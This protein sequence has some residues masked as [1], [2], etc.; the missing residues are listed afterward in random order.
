MIFYLLIYLF[1]SRHLI[2]IWLGTRPGARAP[3]SAVVAVMCAPRR[4]VAWACSVRG[5]SGGGCGLRCSEAPNSGHVLGCQDLRASAH[6]PWPPSLAEAR[7]PALCA[8]LPPPFSPKRS[9]QAP[10][11]LALL[12]FLSSRPRLHMMM[13]SFICSCRNK[14]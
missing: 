11:L 8:P 5:S 2:M 6:G 7:R 12:F 14:K 10:P 1:M 4:Y 13:M 9:L 3:A